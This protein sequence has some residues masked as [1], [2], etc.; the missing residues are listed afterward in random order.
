MSELPSVVLSKLPTEDSKR[1]LF[2]FITPEPVFYK[3]VK[4]FVENAD[5][6]HIQ[7][8]PEQDC[9]IVVKIGNDCSVCLDPRMCI[10]FTIQ[11]MDKEHSL[12]FSAINYVLSEHCIAQSFRPITWGTIYDLQKLGI[13]KDFLLYF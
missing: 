2:T 4:L 10:I 1:M 3:P 7:L 6:T 5:G 9:M 12:I 8:F 11:V 13:K